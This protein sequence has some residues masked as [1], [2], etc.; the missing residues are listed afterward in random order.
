[1]GKLKYVT[2][3]AP[4]K[5]VVRDLIAKPGKKLDV[6]VAKQVR[7]VK[8]RLEI[9]SFQKAYDKLG[10]SLREFGIRFSTWDTIMDMPSVIEIIDELLDLERVPDDDPDLEKEKKEANE[11]DKE[12]LTKI[13]EKLVKFSKERTTYTLD[14]Q[15]IL[16]L[17]G[18]LVERDWSKATMPTDKGPKE[19]T[20][21]VAS[22]QFEAIADFN[23]NLANII[24]GPS[25]EEEREQKKRDKTKEK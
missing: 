17:K 19:I 7:E 20:L 6:E 16:W 10:D 12:K 23:D 8:R 1:M 22:S 14:D 11:R 5:L 24:G 25:I 21:D 15:Y 9:R 18:L 13:R 4:D 3:S 2:L